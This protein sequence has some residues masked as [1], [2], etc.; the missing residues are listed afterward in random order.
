MRYRLDIFLLGWLV[1]F[2]AIPVAG[3][4]AENPQ[5]NNPPPEEEHTLQISL[6]QAVSLALDANRAIAVAR[7]GPLIQEE[8]IKEAW[9]P[10]DPKL[11]STIQTGKANQPFTS[12][13][14][15]PEI[16]KEETIEFSAGVSKA[17]T[18]GTLYELN[19]DTKSDLTNS[20]TRGLNP[21][22]DSKLSLKVTQHLLKDFGTEINKSQIVVA[23]NDKNISEEQFRAKVMDVATQVHQLYWDLV[24]RIED[25]KVK[26]ESLD[27]A[28]DLER[29]VRIQVDVGT[30]PPIEILQAQ[31]SVASREEDVITAESQIRNTEDQLR[32]VLNLEDWEIHIVPLDNPKADRVDLEPVQ[33]L[34]LAKQKRPDYLQVQ[35][36]IESGRTNVNFWNNQKKP[37][38]DLVG[39]LSFQ[40]VSGDAESVFFGGET[41][42][43]SFGG[44]Y[45][46]SLEGLAS[47]D[48][49]NWSVGLTVEYPLGNRKARSNYTSSKLQ[50]EQNQ[51]R[52]RDLE[53]TIQLDVRTS[54]REVTTGWKQIQATRVARQLAQEKLD[55]EVKKF[56]VGESTSFEVLQF[57]TDLAAERSKEILALVTFNQ[58]LAKLDRAVGNSLEANDISIS[59]LLDGSAKAAT[60]NPDRP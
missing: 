10:F 34:E 3:R 8:K 24:F 20:R 45:S 23:Q 25:L 38:V 1:L 2:L 42:I 60:G 55:A 4:G 47:G 35:K 14:A 58:S 29:R 22:Y 13:F 59:S 6:K 40:G 57:Q 17:H 56:E 48:F 33:L 49:L 53:Q 32:Q 16:G 54:I 31:S 5:E 28:K 15:N 19:V 39:N 44:P 7:L 37:Q 12:V 43:S 41:L 50:L 36:E 30:L 51:T 46:D 18:L 21:E 9:S 26:Q 52:L 11:S 27:L